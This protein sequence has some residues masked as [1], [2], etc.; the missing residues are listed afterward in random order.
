MSWFTDQLAKGLDAIRAA[1]GESVTYAA[2][3]DRI[4]IEDAVPR[5][6]IPTDSQQF[7]QHILANGRIWDI[8]ASRLTINGTMFEPRRGHVI[9][10]A[11]GTAWEALDNPNTGKP[12]E[13]IDS[14]K[15]T[16][17]IFTLRKGA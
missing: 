13:Y 14:G 10:E 11:D 12:F 15:N 7:E 17:K 4:T 16:V 1:A 6:I 2:G 5:R 9:I 8:K 3:A